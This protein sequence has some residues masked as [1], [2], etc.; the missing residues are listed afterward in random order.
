MHPLA[1]GMRRLGTVLRRL[2]GS[3]TA[4]AT[5]EQ[6][7]RSNGSGSGAAVPEL[8]ASI[9][10]GRRPRSVTVT[11]RRAGDIPVRVYTPRG[12]ATDR[13]LVV[14]LHGGGFV[15]GD[16][17]GGDWMC[18]IVA[19]AVG[20]VVVSVGYRLAPQ[21]PFPAGVD[22]SYAGLCWAA[23]HAAELG[24]DATRLGI[25]GESAG[26]NLAAVAAI[27]AR[28][29]GGPVIRHQALLYPVTGAFDSAS[30]RENA[31]AFILSGADM[32]RFA[33]LYAGDPH[34]WRVSPL[35]AES[36]AGLP[37]AHV[38][39][40]GHDPLHDDGVEYAAAL[41]AAGGSAELVDYPAMPHGF[42]NF[43]RFARDAKPAMAVVATAQ[44]T[45]L[46]RS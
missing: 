15:Y 4:A 13:P 17:R 6:I 28:D 43:P 36:L 41:R 35:L 34:D 22:D 26:A 24:A 33:E 31:N 11:D 8:A 5:P 7:A 9:L 23:E 20:A 16:L 18:G 39:V 14:Y 30:R 42:L 10:M 12:D 32:E 3:S 37:P 1:P 19:E 45:A 2:P 40:A 38:V 21:H 46:A 44:R 27:T 25:M 29:R